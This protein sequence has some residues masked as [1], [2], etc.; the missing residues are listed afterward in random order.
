MSLTSDYLKL[1]ENRVKKEEEE[2]KKKKNSTTT[3]K[4]SQ[5]KPL[6]SSVDIAPKSPLFSFDEDVAPVLHKV[7][8]SKK[9]E[10]EDTW[11]DSGAF[12]DGYQ[13]GDVAKTVGS[14]AFDAATGIVQGALKLGEGLVDLGAY[15]VSGVSRLVGA[16][17]FADLMKETAKD[18]VTDI[19]VNKFRKNTTWDDNSLLGTKS[20]GVAQGLGQIAGIIAT[21]GAGAAGGLSTAA[22]SVLTMG[23]IGLSSMGSGMSEAY[24]GGATDG[25][26]VA[27]GALSGAIEAGTEMLF[28]GLGKSVKALGLSRGISSLDDVF[29][30]KLSSKISNRIASN[31]VEYSVKS[32]GEGLE[33][34]IAGAGS[35]VAKK[36]T[37]M[38]D[39]ELEQL[40]K[41]ENLLDQFI[42]GTIVS[43]IAQGGNLVKSVKTNTDFV[44]GLNTNEQTVVDKE[45]EKRIAEQ[46]ENGKKLTNKE[47]DKIYDDV[48][49]DLDKGYISTDTIEEALGGDTYKSYK[50]TTESEDALKK[51]LD[52]LRQM[53][54]GE[55]NDIQRDRLAELKAM[56]LDDTTKR[57][58]LKKQLGEEVFG[59][60]KDSRLVE[61]YNER[62][63]RSQAY[64]ADT[65][66]Y[67]AK[68]QTVI[69]NAI[70]SGILNNTNRTHEFVDM[71]AKISADKGV[72]FD[73]TNNERL[74]ESGFAI[75]GKTIN[76]YV[77]KDGVTLNI[78]SAKALNS[79][80]GHETTH[81]LEGTELYN[82]LQKSVIEYAKSK[83]DYQGRYDAL[84]NLYKDVADANI[85]AELTADLVGDYLFTDSD[86][87]NNLSTKHRNVFQ[88]IYDEIKYLCKVAT[89]GSKEARELER[90][91][92]A[93]EKAYR[94]SGKAEGD[95]KYSLSDNDGKKLTNEQNEFFK[96]SKVRDENGNLKVM[97]H[98]SPETFTV[99]DKSKAKAS[100]YY[101]KGFYFTDSDSHAKQYGNTYD[102]YLNIT[103]PIHDGTNNI[104]KE[105]L[106]KF[107]EA[108]A[109]NEDYGIDNY[110]YGATVDSVTNSVYGKSDFAMLMDVNASCVGD[111]VAAIELFNEVNGTDYNG[112]ITPTETVAFYPEQIKQTD[113]KKPTG[114][115]DIRFSLS[116]AVEET[117]DLMAIH[118][119][120]EGKLLKSL[121]LGGL[122]M[123]SV[124]IAKAQNGHDEFGEISLVLPK[125]TIDPKASRNNKLYSG[126]A[127][128]PTYPRVEYK[129][130]KKVLEQ[131]E[132]KI[133]GLVPSDIVHDLGRVSF[134]TDNMTDE[135]NRFGGDMVEAFRRNDALKYAFLKDTG[136]DI[137]LPMK[138]KNISYYGYR[139]NGAIIKVAEA[140][141]QE[142]LQVAQNS[143]SDVK[144]KYEPAIRK[145]VAE[146]MQEKY[147]DTP[148]LLDIMI[149][150]E[151]L[152]F[153]DLDGYINEALHYHKKGV[154]QTVDTQAARELVSEKV[155]QSEYEAWLSELFSGIVEKEG[156]RNNADFFTPSG[157]RRS[158]EA[159]HYEHNLEN[160]VKAMREKGAKGI[161]VIGS[162]NIFGASTTEFDSID[163]MKKS[164][165][166]LQKMSQDE[167]DEIRKEYED[168]FFDLAYR[169]PIHKDSFSAT[170]DA[171]DM[172]VEAVAKYST[173]S[174]IANYLRKESQ[175]WANYS[176][177]IVD[178]LI[179]LVN[180]IRQMPTG[181]FEAKPQRAVG[182]DEVGVFVIPRNADVKLK[183]ELLSRGYAIA[184]YDPDVEG[185]R[186]K[187]VNS[188]EEYKF[189]LS[190]ATKTPKKYGNYNVYGK[191]VMLEQ[192]V[193][194]V[195][196]SVDKAEIPTEDTVSDNFAPT[197][198]DIAEFFPSDPTLD[199]LKREAEGLIAEA[200]KNPE[201]ADTVNRLY[202]QYKE[203]QKKIK[204][205]EAEEAAWN[206]EQL[207]SLDDADAPP[208]IEAP[209]Y[210]LGEDVKPD[211]PFDNRDIKAV[212]NRKV[213]AYMYENPEVKPYFQE[214]ATVLLGELNR[215]QR[216]E[217]YYTPVD[218]VLGV[219]G[220]DS[221][222]VWTGVTRHT[223]PDIAY[224][225]DE[226]GYTYD[227]IEKGIKAIIEDNGKENNA[228]SKRIEF[229]LNDR[230]LKG[231]PDMDY[232]DNEDMY[233][234]PNQEYINLLNE[235]QI[236]EYNEESFK[237]FM[238]SAEEYAPIAETPAPVTENADVAPVKQTEET[239]TTKQTKEKPR[240][241]AE[242]LFEETEGRKKRGIWSLVKEYVLD[243]GM[244]FEDISK[245]HNRRELEARWNS[246]RNSEKAAQRFIKD[247]KNGVRS[248]ET[249][250][251]EIEQSGLIEDFNYYMYH[252][253]NVDRMSLESR[254]AP[255]IAELKEQLGELD[256]AQIAELAEEKIRRGASA[257]DA[258]RIRNAKV[259]TRLTNF[260]NKAVFGESETAEVSQAKVDAWEKGHPEF[261]EWAEEVY[262]NNKLLRQFM[263]DNGILSEETAELWD[264]LYPHYVPIRRKNQ[265]GAAINVPLDTNKTG[266]NAPIKRATGGDSDFYDLFSTMSQR[267]IQTY[268]AV[269]K[270]RFGTEL[271]D[272]LGTTVSQSEAGL[273]DAM[274]SVEDND[275]LLKAGKHGANP[276]FT[277]FEDGKRVEFEISEEM[278]D[279]MRPAGDLLSYTN[280][281]ANKISNF[282]RATLTEYSALFLAKNA[283][284]DMQDVFL[285]SQHAVRTYGAIPE[286]IKEMATGKG[287]I[288]EYL[289]NGGEA[290]TYFDSETNSFTKEN[291]AWEAIKTVTGLNAVQKANNVV[292]MLPRL[293]EYIASRKMG[294]SIDVSMLDAARVTTNFAAGGKLTKMLNRNGATFLNAS[295]QGAIQQVRN[296]REAKMNGLKGV[297]GLAAKVGLVGGTAL[298]LNNLMW[299]D[300]EEYEEL[301]DY[302][303]QNYYI[304]GK[305]GDGK[306]VRI[307]KGRATAVIQNA[308]EQ[309]QNLVTGNDEVDLKAFL[310]LAVSNLAPNDP[311]DNNVLS[312]IMQVK[313]NETW[314]GEDL[315][316]SRLQKLPDAEQYDETTDSLSKWLGEKLDYSP[317]KINYL[318][319]QYSGFV[320]DAVLPMLTPEAES[321]DMPIVGNI[322][323]P[324]LK[325]MAK[326]FVA[327]AY[328]AFTTDSTMKNQNVSDFY[329]MMDEL[330][331]G[332]NASGATDED[333]LKSKYMNSINS[334]LGEL[335]AK[336]R[337]IQNSNLS[338][339]EKYEAVREVQKQITELA[340]NSLNAY[341]NVSIEEYSTHGVSIGEYANV[342]DRYFKRNKDGE[343]EKLDDDAKA[344][345]LATKDAGDSY[346]ATDGENH[347]KWYEPSE[348]S[349]EKPSWKK[350]SDE[351]LEK[352]EEVTS[353]LGI[354]ASDYWGNKDEY[355]YAY[356]Y[357]G[358]YA[359][360]KAVGG[361][362]SY[363]SYSS[364]MNDIGANNDSSSG[365]KDKDLITEYIFGLDLDYGEKAIL[366][367][368]KYSSKADKAEYNN[369][370]VEYLNSR[371]DISYEEMVTIL[372]EL[373]M[374]IGSDGYVYWD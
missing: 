280:E 65:S 164:S 278:Y 322:E 119:L 329:E 339:A 235:K 147:S 285:N 242:I 151:P 220:S 190:D 62:G 185:D 342:G 136:T 114:D 247:G 31:L 193:A 188:F 343:W 102:V 196:E 290:N 139:E 86:F 299:D 226:L 300:D 154:E 107:V 317:Y 76:G 197:A 158:F 266:V 184:E 3:T 77:T 345:F 55:M 148:E 337:E 156:I 324:W 143:G 355:T 126:D 256:D 238:E 131:I 340:E 155:N 176:E 135:L 334:E 215:T 167:Y 233:T 180:D 175:G 291:K 292:E 212:G 260:K 18:N 165:N 81:V 48:L 236:T 17:S 335:Y 275:G 14:T 6:Y 213:K 314:Y 325:E 82:E 64:Q 85:D 140:L 22:T 130:N 259:Y 369:D 206:K 121:K 178:D 298:L 232:P 244:V 365:V 331:V 23:T 183:Q 88:K 270:N 284:K 47:K 374:Y 330:T 287:Y 264:S 251:D 69:Q 255:K 129:V 89:A 8:S 32:S 75:D 239:K 279:A 288:Q 306:F 216:G 57:D 354:S 144:D 273:N 170:S 302:V 142:E 304:V 172:L 116:E 41:D 58:G 305:F 171:G 326:L 246:I 80:V 202:E 265:D 120:T 56:N 353:G 225:L 307:P 283:V 94:E 269:A 127:W 87:I 257:E 63:R 294:R 163:E 125:E 115:P 308:F 356:K 282:R 205:A 39:K 296:V 274:D 72:S 262:A 117:N 204:Q 124:A 38:S 67:D 101:G 228:C 157:N 200:V 261:K 145:A 250:K 333:I 332:A 224:L 346:Y 110:G 44:T 318:L 361:Y 186:Q 35:A 276:T 272:V 50:D 138:E 351:E 16:D 373:D 286:A 83:G 150:K 28:G 263:V 218:G 99:F 74:K 241:T 105:Q 91:K 313:N 98:G 106:R 319:D 133:Y 231:Y 277:I 315:V 311:I 15:G 152:S 217:R 93:F 108:V 211:D 362:D 36:L 237:R 96:D 162:G 112:I 66:K 301:S 12:D 84:T 189:S 221:Y 192:D 229:L 146:Y 358:K 222:G 368:S 42:T 195:A 1:R 223:S 310:D 177:D 159:L 336:K 210:S 113:N 25:Q 252:K 230:L 174:G 281:V 271:L 203:L 347:Y 234:P 20:Q 173:R 161:G 182:F 71:I 323:Q 214:A 13:F 61:S 160:V 328:D 243:N 181:Y 10:K 60:V 54:S 208:E 366:Y 45:V 371:D 309:M 199:D 52:E 293:A 9:T 350:I 364:V 295:V 37:Y 122:P 149:P 201:D 303:K 59:L 27:Y 207:A 70:D 128:T 29:A 338:D 344:K 267:A 316:P 289:D 245:K 92:R 357:P 320:G 348:D 349:D 5:D 168:R 198:E 240:K 134:D 68:Q 227:E 268:K 253:H 141:T 97:H 327:P 30:K 51:E 153:S 166:R 46:E 219:Y 187:V 321:G 179:E 360:S 19:Y 95:T 53:K 249:L 169:L 352:Q 33:E 7:N 78:Q 40:V 359:I 191:D 248:I 79:V 118:N 111:M 194:P 254:V 104:T 132:D 21:G 4:A 137:A 90:V 341:D 11:F 109:E 367:R 2:K 26:A 297:L 370:I 209:Y 363:K 372:E 258:N 49:S 312:P 100:G 123:P 103:N 24:Q 34:V 43:G 73:F